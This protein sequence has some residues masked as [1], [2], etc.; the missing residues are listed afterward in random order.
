MATIL[1][2]MTKNF[3]FINFKVCVVIF[4]SW[5]QSSIKKAHHKQTNE[6]SFTIDENFYNFVFMSQNYFFSQK[7]NF[8]SDPKSL[9]L[10]LC[11]FWHPRVCQK[12]KKL[13]GIV[14]L[15]VVLWEQK[16]KIRIFTVWLKPILIPQFYCK[17]ETNFQEHFYFLSTRI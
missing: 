14:L 1:I 6:I 15:W 7:I 9:V 5:L 17:V 2:L 12:M 4:F 16:W 13:S 3:C 10:N 11:Q 8:I